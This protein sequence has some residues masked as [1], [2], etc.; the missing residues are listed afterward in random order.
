MDGELRRGM[1]EV[2]E[3]NEVNKAKEAKEKSER[4][5]PRCADSAPLEAR[6]KRNDGVFL[7]AAVN[8]CPRGVWLRDG[9]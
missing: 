1:K 8:G 6:G 7:F 3:V 5:I 9:C 2:N 4:V